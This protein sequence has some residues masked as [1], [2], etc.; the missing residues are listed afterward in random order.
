[1]RPSPAVNDQ[2]DVAGRSSELSSQHRRADL[3]RNVASTNLSHILLSQ[4]R[5]GCVRAMSH[6]KSSLLRGVS[7]VRCLVAEKE[8]GVVHAGWGVACMTD[9]EAI[10]DLAVFNRPGEAMGENKLPTRQAEHAIALRVS[11]CSPEPAASCLVDM[12][13]EAVFGWSDAVFAPSPVAVAKPSAFAGGSSASTFAQH[14]I[15]SS[16]G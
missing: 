16:R 9:A 15:D 8:V 2:H 1:M 10:G 3:T 14:L 13:P 7:H 5:P 6:R 4:L 12:F 11:V